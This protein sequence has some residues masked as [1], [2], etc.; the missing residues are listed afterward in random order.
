MRNGAN[1]VEGEGG[2]EWRDTIVSPGA[3][4]P[5]RSLRKPYNVIFVS[6]QLSGTQRKK[7]N[8]SVKEE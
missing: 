8:S 5:E 2:R 3:C 6:L 1:K 4:I 7:K